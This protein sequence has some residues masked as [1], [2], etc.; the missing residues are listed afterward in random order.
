MRF[1]PD[2]PTL[3]FAD[4]IGFSF[5]LRSDFTCFLLS[6]CS[7]CWFTVCYDLYK[8]TNI[9][10]Y[11]QLYIFIT[12]FSPFHRLHVSFTPFLLFYRF[13]LLFLYLFTSLYVY[14]S[15]FLYLCISI[16]L[17]YHVGIYLSVFIYS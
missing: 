2:S 12:N 11:K 4:S 14:I 17:Y 10:L 15:A 1:S 5:F 7:L 16:S 9:F 8:H 6:G 13:L 3:F